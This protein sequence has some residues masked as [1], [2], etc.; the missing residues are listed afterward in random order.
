MG[1][2][3]GIDTSN[4][5]SSAALYD[6]ET[7]GLIQFKKPLPVKQGDIGLRQSDAVFHHTVQLPDL[8]EKL[9][10]SYGGK[11]SAVSVSSKPRPLPGSYMPCFMA[12]VAAARAVSYSNGVPLYEFSHQTGHIAAALYSAK[13]T[14]LIER[15]FIAFHISGGT[16]EALLVKPDFQT[17]ISEN[18]ISKSLDLKAGQAVDRVGVMLGLPFPAGAGLDE[19]SKKSQKEYKIK[20][21]LKNGC[22]CLSGIENQC[23]KMLESGEKAEDIAKFLIASVYANI[24]AMLCFI[25]EGFGSLPVVFAGGVASNSYIRERLSQRAEVY[26][27]EPQF[28]SDNAAGIAILGYLKEKGYG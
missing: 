23:K 2:Y 20:A 10:A 3:L 9:F 6:G 13:K 21:K 18:I 25:E 24:E 1:A 12:G 19:M 14:E 17:I 22:C 5:T 27:A 8:L 11:L 7:D 15:E 4:Y 16:T 26:F 28:S